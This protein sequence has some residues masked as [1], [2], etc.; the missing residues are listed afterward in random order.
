MGLVLTYTSTMRCP[1]A[2]FPGR[3]VQSRHMMDGGDIWKARGAVATRI[4][5]TPGSV[6]S[7]PGSVLGRLGGIWVGGTAWL[8][9]PPCATV[10]SVTAGR[11]NPPRVA[12]GRDPSQALTIPVVTQSCWEQLLG[13]SVPVL[14]R[15]QQPVLHPCIPSPLPGRGMQS[16]GRGATAGGELAQV[17]KQF[18]Q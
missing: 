4:I 14:S 18:G 7:L 1:W 13:S 15:R 10:G 8:V 2:T 12:A 3:Q 16:R 11:A 5:L 17:T 6:S 9:H